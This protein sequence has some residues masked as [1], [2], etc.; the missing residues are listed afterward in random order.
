MLKEEG[1]SAADYV[2]DVMDVRKK[3]D[4][5]CDRPFMFVQCENVLPVRRSS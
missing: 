5:S 3:E 2:R 4:R 1:S